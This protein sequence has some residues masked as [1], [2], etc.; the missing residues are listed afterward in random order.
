MTLDDRLSR[1]STVI[2]TVAG[3][4]NVQGTGFYYNR[5]APKEGEGAQWRAVT[6][7]HIVTNRH[8]VLPRVDDSE[9]SPDQ[10]TF[11]LRKMS[12]EQGLLD[13][14]D[15]VLFQGDIAQRAKFHPDASVDL[16]LIDMLDLLTDRVQHS[17]NYVAPTTLSPEDFVSNNEID[18]IEVAS[19]VIVVGYPRGFY[20]TANLFPIVKSGIVASRWGARFEGQRYF[21]ID[22]KLFPGSSG[23]AV[24]SEP[25]DFL[26]KNGRIL[27]AEEKQFA[28]LGVYSG[29]HM[30]IDRPVE[31]GDLTI[32]RRTS[33]DLGVVWYADLIE[34]ILDGG[35]D[36]HEALGS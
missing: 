19:N 2:T 16:A 9:R 8:V 21:L 36:L 35:I 33:L 34:E 3:A 14:E 12:D 17:T 10:V 1:I 13:W 11:R 26:I 22:A 27:T 30:L 5:L 29:D 6:E 15:V 31:V 28:F 7:M 23:S 24:L 32:V 25:R 18:N 20:D 4:T